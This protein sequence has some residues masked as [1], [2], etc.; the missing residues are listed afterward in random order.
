MLEAV[1]TIFLIASKSSLQ[2][3]AKLIL[4]VDSGF[5]H[6]SSFVQWFAR[7]P[8]LGQI[9]SCQAVG[10]FLYMS[11]LSI[12]KPHQTCSAVRLS[13]RTTQSV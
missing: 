2:M 1:G 10:T 11:W 9:Q 5:F 13:M 3:L 8:L 7:N 4:D 12:M 6:I